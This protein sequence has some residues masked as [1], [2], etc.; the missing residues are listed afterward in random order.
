MGEEAEVVAW[1]RTAL[2]LVLVV[3]GEGQMVT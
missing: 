3:P 1:A 2:L